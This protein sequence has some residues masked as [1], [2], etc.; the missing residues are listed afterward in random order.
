MEC[1]QRIEAAASFIS[2]TLCENAI[3]QILKVPLFSRT[4]SA[5]T[6]VFFGCCGLQQI[7][8]KDPDN[9]ES[10][11][12]FKFFKAIGRAKEAG[13]RA[14]KAAEFDDA[15]TK[16]TECLSMDR[17]N[18]KFNCVIYANR[19]AVWLR[20]K[21]WQ[22]AFDDS[23]TAISL[24]SSYIKAY[25]RRIQALYKLDRFDEAVGD[26]ERALKLDPSSNE[27][28]Q[29]LREVRLPQNVFLDHIHSLII[30]VH[31]SG[32]SHIF[33]VRSLVHSAGDYGVFA[34]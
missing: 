32:D 30:N 24:D 10:R 1:H 22:N 18:L 33:Y 21:E 2:W 26:A 9:T 11:K 28:K 8:R 27:L 4:L 13:N 34:L 29:Q 16:Y 5:K 7:L 23:T 6:L 12:L 14:F 3:F 17:T 20:Q 15:I 25:G 31:F 19:A